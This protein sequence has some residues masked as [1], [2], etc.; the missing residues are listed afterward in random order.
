MIPYPSINP[1]AF[2]IGPLA[3]RWYGI[4]YILGFL[5]AYGILKRL[6]AQGRVTLRREAVADLMSWLVAGLVLGARVGYVLFYNL[7]HFVSEPWKIVAVW[8]GGM[9]FHG[10]LVGVTAAAWL[11]AR[12]GSIRFA[13]LGDML[14]VAAP[15][16]LFFGRIANFING[17]L[18]GR[19]TDLPWG[20]VF[21]GE[22]EPR[23]PSQLYEAILE[24]LVLW[25]IVCWAWQRW[26]RRPGATLSVFLAG[27]GA[28]RFVV[29]F[30]REPDAQLGFILGFLTMG[31][32]LSLA[33]LAAG[34]WAWSRAKEAAAQPPG[35]A[36]RDPAGTKR[37]AK[38][39]TR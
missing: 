38:R 2:R 5:C 21:P 23:H 29:E 15:P 1:V 34:I 24:G 27:Y 28:L 36:P 12:R 11:F 16:G 10:G 39:R 7:P 3:V 9:S 25:A 37:A 20:M 31:Q 4:A 8:E 13:S 32:I 18:Y 26:W 22:S 17:E 33:T 6:A 30:T 19:V 14:V 35:Q